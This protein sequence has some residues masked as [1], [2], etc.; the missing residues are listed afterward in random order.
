MEFL[1][2]YAFDSGFPKVSMEFVTRSIQL[3]AE[4]YSSQQVHPAVEFA[5]AL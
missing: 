4:T 1:P 3:Q 2:L 5:S